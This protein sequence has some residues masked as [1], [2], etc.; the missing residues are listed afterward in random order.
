MDFAWIRVFYDK[1][2]DLGPWKRI[3]EDLAIILKNQEINNPVFYF[4]FYFY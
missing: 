4:Y 2:K 1:N 3:D